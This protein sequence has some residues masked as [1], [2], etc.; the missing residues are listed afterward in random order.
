MILKYKNEII[1]LNNLAFVIIYLICS[2]NFIRNE[3]GR[4]YKYRLY[5]PAEVREFRS[6]DERGS[7][8]GLPML[9]FR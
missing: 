7:C 4:F 8:T 2:I 3:N 5:S 9:F 6:E 1:I